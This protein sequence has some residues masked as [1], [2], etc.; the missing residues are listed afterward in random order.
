MVA[1]G[2]EAVFLLE[3]PASSLVMR[4]DRFLWLLDLWK[5]P[6]LHLPVFWLNL[7]LEPPHLKTQYHYHKYIKTL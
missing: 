6:S 5:T 3:Q 4:H 7:F 1:V 2:K